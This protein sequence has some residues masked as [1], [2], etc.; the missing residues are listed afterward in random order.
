MP[1]TNIEPVAIVLNNTPLTGGYKPRSFKA[2]LGFP[3]NKTNTARNGNQIINYTSSDSTTAIGKVTFAVYPRQADND[4]D[5][6]GEIRNLINNTI[7]ILFFYVGIMSVALTKL[8][9]KNNKKL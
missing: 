6:V 1:N 7:G 2:T 3:K 8:I 4:E 5:I 9:L